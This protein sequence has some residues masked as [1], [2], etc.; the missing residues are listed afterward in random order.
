MLIPIATSTNTAGTAITL[1]NLPNSILID[2]SGNGVFLG[3]SSGVMIYK[4]SSATVSTIALNGRVLA[5]SPDSNYLLISDPVSNTVFYYGITSGLLTSSNAGFTA[6]SSDFV[7][8]SKFNEWVSGTTLAA[9]LQI[10]VQLGLPGNAFTTLPYTAPALD[11]SAQG[12]LTYITGNNPGEI[13]VR[14][15]C[16]QAEGQVFS[17]NVPTLI[18]AL[19]N[20]TGAVAADSPNLDVVSTPSVLSPGCPLTTQST[21]SNVPMGAGPFG[22]RQLFLSSDSSRA[23]VISDLPQLMYLNLQ[24]LQPVTIPYEG[25]AI[26]FS[27]GIT[28]DTLQVY[29]GTSDGTVHRI[30]STAN[31]DV[32]QIPVNLKD[33]NG[34]PVVPDLVAVQP[35]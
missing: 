28:P 24:T 23:W 22:T 29:V 9:G 7:P 13:D 15:T 5:I 31:A 30:D 27:G 20:G 4:I 35:H 25:Q 26:A 34:N 17:V 11:I 8:D 32:Q 6:T 10:G 14:S 12:G 16:N 18:K 19:P 2:P 33:A 1:P 3:S 21:I